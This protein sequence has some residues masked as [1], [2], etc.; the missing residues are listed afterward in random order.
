V[1]AMRLAYI[2]QFKSIH[3]ST[4]KQLV[5]TWAAGRSGGLNDVQVDVH[6]DQKSTHKISVPRLLDSFPLQVMRFASTS[7]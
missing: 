2:C 4:D 5:N 3:S 7:D 1:D 6:H